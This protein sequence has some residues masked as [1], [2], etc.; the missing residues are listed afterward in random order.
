MI[1]RILILAAMSVPLSSCGG[2]D[3]GSG[4]NGGGGVGGGPPA[5]QTCPCNGTSYPAGTC[6]KCGGIYQY[7][8]SNG[9]WTQAQMGG[10][11]AVPPGCR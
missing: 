9:Q 3:S 5:A 11:G 7:C 6:I 4:D 1:K 2:G 8:G 10:G